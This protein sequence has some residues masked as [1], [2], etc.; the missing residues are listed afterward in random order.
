MS[1]SG[2]TTST[3]GH[4]VG[5]ELVGRQVGIGVDVPRD[6]SSLSPITGSSGE[7]PDERTP[8]TVP[9]YS[10]NSTRGSMYTYQEVEQLEY[11]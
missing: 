8:P 5:T 1:T 6:Q 10:L 4:G 7:V 3:Y 11:E 9:S 2:L